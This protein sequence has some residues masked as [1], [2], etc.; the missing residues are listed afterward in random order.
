MCVVLSHHVCA[1][2]SQQPLETNIPSEYLHVEKKGRE[3]FPL[4]YRHTVT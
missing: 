3:Y 2:L 4:I 1:D